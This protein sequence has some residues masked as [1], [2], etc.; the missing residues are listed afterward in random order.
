MT[1]IRLDNAIINLLAFIGSVPFYFFS[2]IKLNLRKNLIILFVFL[3]FLGIAQIDS[4]TWNL[5][6]NP[7]K[8]GYGY[9][10][11]GE[12][13]FEAGLKLEYIKE[14]TG[15]N[16]STITGGQLSRHDQVTYINPFSTIRY[17]KP[18]DSQTGLKISISYNYRKI[19]SIISQSITPEIGFRFYSISTISFGHNFFL[20]NKFEWVTRN[21]I[22]L[23]VI[24]Y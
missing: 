17:L 12:H 13:L 24:L 10:Y 1:R 5:R 7:C 22:A 23:R 4:T 21:R 11:Q 3:S 20:D 15:E 16:V 14:S 8:L 9:I 2:I 19:N 18:F 6:F